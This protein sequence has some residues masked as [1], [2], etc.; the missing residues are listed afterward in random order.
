MLTVLAFNVPVTITLPI[1]S[2][3]TIPPRLRIEPLTEISGAGKFKILSPALLKRLVL[4]A[5]VP[6]AFQ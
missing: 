5:L 1:V 3:L 6:G 2:R 4:N